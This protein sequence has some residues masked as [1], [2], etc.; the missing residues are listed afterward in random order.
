MANSIV[1]GPVPSR[2]LGRSIGINNIPPKTCSYAC[3]YCQL[4]KTSRMMAGREFFYDPEKII[5]AVKLKIKHAR[6]KDESVDYLT[7]VSDGEPTLDCNLGKEIELLKSFGI[8]IAVITNASLIWREDV[9]QDLQKADWEI[10]E[11]L[12]RD[13]KLIEVDYSGMKFY[14][15]RW[16]TPIT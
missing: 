2:R 6:E 5:N 11:K 16:P 7:F 15:R 3:V 14:V 12:L 8:K 10:I 1:F 9:R 13:G 4:G